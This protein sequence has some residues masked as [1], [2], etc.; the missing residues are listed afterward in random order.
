MNTGGPLTDT[1]IPTGQTMNPSATT[2]FNMTQNLD[3]S[4]AVG[5]ATTGSLKVYDSL[6]KSYE[7]TVTYTKTGTY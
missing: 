4:D 1:A 5:A 7:A 6:G 3:S 2:T